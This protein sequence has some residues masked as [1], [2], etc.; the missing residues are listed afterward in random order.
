MASISRSLRTT[1]SAW[2]LSCRRLASPPRLTP[3]SF[4]SISRAYSDQGS[5]GAAQEG[6]T[7]TKKKTK[8]GKGG[9]S[10][11]RAARKER[12]WAHRTESD[13]TEKRIFKQPANSDNPIRARFAP[14]PTGY[15]HLGSLRTALFNNLLAVATKGQF[16]IRIEDTDQ[17]SN[18]AQ[19]YYGSSVLIA[20]RTVL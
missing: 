8:N 14:S 5:S 1:R 2:C 13:R 20:S 4:A 16:I 17:V 3:Y 11:L 6:E 9:L 7:P 12:E 10:A 19:G 18:P 15:I